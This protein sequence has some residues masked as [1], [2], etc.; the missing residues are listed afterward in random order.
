MSLW[1]EKY[2]PKD[3]NDIL[4]HQR[5]IKTIQRFIET[6]ELPHL[7]L[8]GSA[9]TG[10]TSTILSIIKHIYK[11]NMKLMSLELN[12]SDNRNIKVV[13]E[14]IKEFASTGGMF[15]EGY[16]IIVLDEAD[17]MTDSA[18]SCLLRIIETYTQNVRFCLICNYI[19]KIIPAIR[20]R[21]LCFHFYPIPRNH[22]SNRLKEILKEEQIQIMPDALDT[23][24][25][26]SKG[27]MRKC[28][29]MLQSIS[30]TKS[31]KGVTVNDVHNLL[32]SPSHNEIIMMVKH[33]TTKRYKDAFKY[34]YDLKTNNNYNLMCIIGK[35]HH[36]I[37][38]QENNS[39]LLV[40]YAELEENVAKGVND[41]I[42]IGCLV[43]IFQENQ[44]N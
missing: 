43:G 24:I 4:S 16:K 21:C 22:I 42:A 3:L 32:G 44:M 29:N 14:T 33:M 34:I 9:G 26:F 36:Y 6:G 31:E 13:R 37:V 41:K 2:R 38:N 17:S 7:L 25:D 10:K 1:T 5:I 11:D 8:Y 39:E 30:I 27:D 12:A 19:N 15:T 28:L 35:L 18:Q 20:S 40:R 23:V